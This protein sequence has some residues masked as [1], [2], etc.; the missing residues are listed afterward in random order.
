MTSTANSVIRAKIELLVAIRGGSP[1]KVIAKFQTG[2]TGSQS[3]SGIQ[4]YL[5]GPGFLNILLGRMAQNA[6]FRRSQSHPG[7]YHTIFRGVKQVTLQIDGKLVKFS[8]R[9][10]PSRIKMQL[11]RWRLR[12]SYNNHG[13]LRF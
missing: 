2:L 9:F 12:A 10:V 8:T 5:R 11:A 7:G 6:F 1:S 4:S 13:N 3:K